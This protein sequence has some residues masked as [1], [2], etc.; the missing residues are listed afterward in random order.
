MAS[1]ND[2]TIIGNLGKDPEVRYTKSNT[3]VCNFSVATSERW[4]DGSGAPQEKTEWH[5]VVA[6]KRLAEICGEHLAKGRSVYVRGKLQTRSW[7]DNGVKKYKTEIVAR[8]VQFLGSRN[9]DGDGSCNSSK[10]QRSDAAGGGD[11]SNDNWG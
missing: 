8:E 3:A 2:V 9:N 1:V 7:D 11:K 10:A 4:K 6:W 5:T